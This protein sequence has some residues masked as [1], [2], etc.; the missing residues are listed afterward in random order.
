MGRDL[1][2]ETRVERA[3]ESRRSKQQEIAFR[4]LPQATI[5]LIRTSVGGDHARSG[6]GRWAMT[7]MSAG[8]MDSTAE[9]LDHMHAQYRQ[10]GQERQRAPQIIYPG[11]SCPHD[12]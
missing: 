5:P 12:D 2:A 10:G 3:P 11:A 4:S 6:R 7:E 9:E 8:A 1:P